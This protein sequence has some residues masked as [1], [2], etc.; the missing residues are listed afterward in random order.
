[1]E[2]TERRLS[3]VQRE[4][5]DARGLAA[6]ATRLRG[7][8]DALPLPEYV[9]ALGETELATGKTGAAKQ[10]LALVAAEEQLQRAAGVDVDVELAVFEADHG[11]PAKAVT[12]ARRGWSKAPSVRA[13]DALGWALTRGGDPKAG[14]AWAKRALKLGALDPVWRAHAGLSALAAGHANAGREQL[15]IAF[16]HGLAG[17]PWQAQRAR[18]ALR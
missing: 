6:A 8:V 10:D 12:L 17:Y 15:R 18:A 11:D 2:S 5:L 16:A 1:M 9:I 3:R 13:A 14:Y 4:K 7:I